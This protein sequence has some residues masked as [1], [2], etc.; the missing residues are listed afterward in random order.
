MLPLST[1]STTVIL[2]LAS[3]FVNARTAP[4]RLEEK[5]LDVACATVRLCSFLPSP[6]TLFVAVL[7]VLL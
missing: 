1:L 6:F 4:A 3:T 2:L 7:T 5:R